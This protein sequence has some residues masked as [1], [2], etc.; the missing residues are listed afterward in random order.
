MVLVGYIHMFAN[1][2][3]HI[4]VHH[5]TIILKRRNLEFSIREYGRG[6][7]RRMRGRN[8]SDVDVG[9]MWQLLK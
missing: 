6:W 4:Y 2:Y 1:I 9:L 7:R 5:A 8:T 3:K